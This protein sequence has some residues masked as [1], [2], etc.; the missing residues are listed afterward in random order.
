MTG[1]P[2]MNLGRSVDRPGQKPWLTRFT[3]DHGNIEVET[4]IPKSVLLSDKFLFAVWMAGR[5]FSKALPGDTE[6]DAL[7]RRMEAAIQVER[8][9]ADV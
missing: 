9:P 3:D 1:W 6:L 7:R 8:E 2:I 4:Y 5:T